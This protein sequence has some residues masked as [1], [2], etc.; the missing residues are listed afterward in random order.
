MVGI[1]QCTQ[2]DMNSRLE[3]A[4][5]AARLPRTRAMALPG[6]QNHTRRTSRLSSMS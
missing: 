5:Q 1:L 3:Q 4:H 2:A 6:A